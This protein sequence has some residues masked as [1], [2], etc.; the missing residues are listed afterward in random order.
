MSNA[1]CQ[2][3]N[4]LTAT[5]QQVKIYC[6]VSEEIREYSPEKSRGLKSRNDPLYS[7]YILPRRSS[8]LITLSRD[9]GIPSW[10]L[11]SDFSVSF[12]LLFPF[13]SRGGQSPE[14]AVLD[15]GKTE[16]GP[17]FVA[18]LSALIVRSGVYRAEYVCT[19]TYIYDHIHV[20]DAASQISLSR[21]LVICGRGC[22]M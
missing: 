11:A 3:L 2:S 12:S 8:D 1:R 6:D 10:K 14:F 16:S 17:S 18:T 19:C 22:F 21:S 9:I 7:H 13:P 20:Q 5:I 4:V 15:L